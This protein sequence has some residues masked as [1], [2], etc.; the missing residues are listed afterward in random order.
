MYAVC[1]LARIP[2]VGVLAL[3]P[4]AHTDLDRRS[5]RRMMRVHRAPATRYD[6]LE[7]SRKKELLVLYPTAGSTMLYQK[8]RWDVQD[9][10]DCTICERVQ[11]RAS[12]QERA[13]V[14]ERATVQE[15]ASVQRSSHARSRTH[16]SRLASHRPVSRLR[17]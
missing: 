12:V 11:E 14:E 2:I 17:G 5:V 15:R 9:V 8:S 1:L 13:N 16:M 7:E 6:A 10:Q 3:V 4:C